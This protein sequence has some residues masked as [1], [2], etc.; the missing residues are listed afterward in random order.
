[1]RLGLLGGSDDF[2]FAGIG[3]ASGDVIAHRAM[4]KDAVLFHESDMATQAILGNC[5]DILPINCDA[6]AFGL[7]KP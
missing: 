6:A 1:M 5:P 3:A 7:I 2:F 4:Q